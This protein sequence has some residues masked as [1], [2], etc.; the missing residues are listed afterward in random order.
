MFRTKVLDVSD[1]GNA[2]TVVTLEHEL[3]EI[4]NSTGNEISY[5]TI[6]EMPFY[7]GQGNWGGPRG[8]THRVTIDTLPTSHLFVQCYQID[9]QIPIQQYES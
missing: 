8:K 1:K 2:G 3:Y 9:L 6:T 4:G 5:C 7:L